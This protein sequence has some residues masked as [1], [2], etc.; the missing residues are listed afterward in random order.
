MPGGPRQIGD[1]V[2]HTCRVAIGPEFYWALGGAKAVRYDWRREVAHVWYGGA[3]VEVVRLS[4]GMAVDNW[5]RQEWYVTKPTKAQ[6]TA[7]MRTRIRRRS[8]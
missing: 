4:D 3:G 5:G 8:L 1:K 7:A 2:S 6:V